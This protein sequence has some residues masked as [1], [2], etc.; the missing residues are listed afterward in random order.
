MAKNNII[1]KKIW[2]D[3]ELME[4]ETICSSGVITAISKIYVSVSLLD[5]LIFQIKSF[6]EGHITEGAWANENKGNDSTACVTFRF[7]KKNKLGHIWIEVFMELDDGGDYSKHNCCFYIDTEIG[8]LANF[9]DDL[10]KLKGNFTEIEV[11]LNK[12]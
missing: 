9:C 3:S 4:L 8:L 10:T 6:L 2:Q 1:F 5:E 11:Q 12:D 7:L